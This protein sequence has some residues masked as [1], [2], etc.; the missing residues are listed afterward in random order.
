MKERK[1]NEFWENKRICNDSLAHRLSVSG[2]CQSEK[3][4]DILASFCARETLSIPSLSRHKQRSGRQ[5]NVYFQQDRE[6]IWSLLFSNQRQER[7][8]C[9][10]VASSQWVFTSPNPAINT[11]TKRELLSSER[12]F[13]S[14]C[15]R[16]RGRKIVMEGSLAVCKHGVRRGRVALMMQPDCHR[17]QIKKRETTLDHYRL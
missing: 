14:I 2:F 17:S 16:P 9:S 12:G 10:I 1:L 13:W 4:A 6:D 8:D 5:N 11:A 7:D 15:S 3:I